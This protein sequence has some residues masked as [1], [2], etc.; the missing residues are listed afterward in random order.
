VVITGTYL[1]GARQVLFGGV[2]TSFTIT[3]P[4]QISATAPAEA[5]GTVDVLVIGPGGSS[6]PTTVD[7]FTF[8]TPAPTVTGVSSS[9]GATA[10]GSL[11]TITGTNFTGA[12]QVYF[13]TTLAP[14]FHVNSDTSITAVSPLLAA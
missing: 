12:T 9:S 13:G 14:L 1:S 11:V 2:A 7:Q 6:A 4:G 3:S 10:G 5:A 8:L